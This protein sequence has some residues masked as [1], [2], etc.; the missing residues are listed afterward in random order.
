MP[1]GASE[2]HAWFC[3]WLT[4][5]GLCWLLL[6]A[7]CYSHCT[8]PASKV[9][10]EPTT[11]VVHWSRRLTAAM[12]AMPLN[13]RLQRAG[14]AKVRLQK[15]E[16]PREAFKRRAETENSGFVKE[17]AVH[18]FQGPAFWADLLTLDGRPENFATVTR[19]SI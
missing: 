2:S 6:V 15:P 18:P 4:E 17:A 5:A 11:V 13:T 8:A 7:S 19:L 14:V 10:D 3:F 12:P 16:I 9:K 1:G